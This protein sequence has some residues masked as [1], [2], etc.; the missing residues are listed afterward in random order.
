MKKIVTLVGLCF[1]CLFAFAETKVLSEKDNN[2]G[3]LISGGDLFYFTNRMDEY[4]NTNRYGDE[5]FAN[6]FSFEVGLFNSDEDGLFDFVTSHSFGFSSGRINT[7]DN[8]SWKD[9]YRSFEAGNDAK[10]SNFYFKDLFG[11]QINFFLLSAGVLFGSNIGY[12]WLKMDAEA[13]NP[14]YDYVYKERRIFVDFV[15][16]PYFSVNIRHFVKIYLA[17]EIDL[18]ILRLRFIRDSYYR[19][20]HFSCDFFKDDIPTVYKLGVVLFF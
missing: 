12:D 16:Q 1:A 3:L 8:Y 10:F 9:S 5:L 14:T 19:D 11:P 2:S 15:I 17:T 7:M 4:S 20:Y 13:L 18:P 6:G